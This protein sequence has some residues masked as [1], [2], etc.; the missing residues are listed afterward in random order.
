MPFTIGSGNPQGTFE[1]TEDS[2]IKVGN[3][4]IYNLPVPASYAAAA[5]TNYT[6]SDILGGVI[7][8]AG[9]GASAHTGNLPTAS[10]LAAAM[11]QFS[12]RGVTPGDSLWVYIANT[13]SGAGA[14][15]L[16]SAGGG[17]FD[18]HAA[19][20]IAQNTSREILIRFTSGTPGSEAY[21]VYT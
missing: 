13:S 3:P 20:T 14:F 1:E 4:T 21:V 19:Q 7:L 18:T 2:A 12:S 5:T 10:A 15:T 8:D 11:R 16:G 6:P 9:N 17:T